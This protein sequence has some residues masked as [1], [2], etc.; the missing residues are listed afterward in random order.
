MFCLMQMQLHVTG[1]VGKMIEKRVLGD[2]MV[3]RIG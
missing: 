2:R 3:D 1:G